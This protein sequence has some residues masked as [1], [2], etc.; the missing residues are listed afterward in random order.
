MSW[1]WC[2]LLWPGHCHYRGWKQKPQDKCRHQARGP[3]AV[4]S[5]RSWRV[6]SILLLPLLLL[7]SLYIRVSGS[8]GHNHP[9]TLKLP[10]FQN[11]AEVLLEED[12]IKTSRLQ[13][14]KTCCC[15]RRGSSTEDST[16]YLVFVVK[17]VDLADITINNKEFFS[18]ITLMAC[19]GF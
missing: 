12:D 2:W 6:W 10:F 16:W 9:A 18:M 1:L 14:N 7:L 4:W 15:N 8:L 17:F 19:P 3:V 5:C 13:E 11:E